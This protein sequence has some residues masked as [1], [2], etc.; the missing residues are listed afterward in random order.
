[1]DIQRPPALKCLQ[2]RWYVADSP[3]LAI[4]GLPSSSKLGIVQL[5]C[6][7]KLTSRH[8]APSPPMKPTAE[9]IKVRCDLTFP[10]NCSKDLIKAYPDQFDGIGQ[11]PGTYHITLYDDANAVVHAPRKCP[12]AMWPL[13]HEKLDEFIDQG[14]IV[15]VEEPTDWVSSLAHTWKGNGKLWVCLNPKDLNAVNRCD[16]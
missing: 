8:D 11:F 9:C 14:I 4:L 13:V 2:T 15:P 12:I 5:N 16:D 1:M 6:A 3:G 10:I 7:V